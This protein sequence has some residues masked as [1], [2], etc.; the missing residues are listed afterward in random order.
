MREN[1]GK[2]EM[3]G[4][5]GEKVDGGGEKKKGRER[6]GRTGREESLGQIY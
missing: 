2:S 1:K 6:R 4:R 5:R 3:K